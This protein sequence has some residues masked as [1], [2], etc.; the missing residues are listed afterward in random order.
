MAL[1]SLKLPSVSYSFDSKGTAIV[2]VTTGA[3]DKKLGKLEIVSPMVQMS[4][5]FS[6]I[7]KSLINLVNFAKK[8]FGLEEKKATKKKFEDANTG[9]KPTKAGGPSMIDTLSKALGGIGDAFGKV[10]IGEKLG[11]ALLVGALL[12]FKSVQGVLVSV[13]TPIV[14]AVKGLIKILGPKGTMMLFIGTWALIK[15]AP[16]IAGVASVATTFGKFLMTN[17]TVNEGFKKMITQGGKFATAT[18][19]FAKD[20]GKG[21]L[22]LT[23]SIGSTV[24]KSLNYVGGQLVT[25]AQGTLKGLS[26]GMMKSMRLLGT[27]FKAMRV[28]MMGTMLPAISGMFASMIPIAIAAAPFILMG[29]AIVAGIAAVFFSLKSAF[30]VFQKSRDDGDSMLTAIG[31]AVLDFQATLL[32]LPITL[33][34][35]LIGYVAGL[36]G[37]DGIKE[38]LANFSFK[39]AFVNIIISFIDKVKNFFTGLMNFDISKLGENIAGIGSTI[40]NIMK[41]LGK[42]ALAFVK[43]IPKM[44]FGGEHPTAAFGRVYNEV[45][46]GGEAKE[47][48]D[49][50]SSSSIETSA[51][52]N[53]FMETNSMKEKNSQLTK[54]QIEKTKIENSVKNG[55]GTIV[56]DNSKAGDVYNQK[57]DVNVSGEIS[58][59]HSDPTSR[60]INDAMMA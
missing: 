37:F 10:S 57:K 31:K 60:M 8:T 33:V 58:T 24:F 56:V 48:N 11:A 28:F 55:S 27:V 38:K 3:G 34:K 13:L 17:K 15:F 22:G 47:G 32:T 45:R 46:A 54:S 19:K 4:E 12:L 30:A 59:E 6:G 43:A 51:T 53:K 7:D 41:A 49:K 14:A 42:G 9:G 18:G 21:L 1:G 23:K 2:P 44:L 16:L 50:V 39:D 36:L 40:A 29:A 52:N 26:G 35:N 25:V 20:L 5:F